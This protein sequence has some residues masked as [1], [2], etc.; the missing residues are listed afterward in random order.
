MTAMAN[1]AVSK[2]STQVRIA[3]SIAVVIVLLLIGGFAWWLTRDATVKDDAA[4]ADIGV[5]NESNS[6][7]VQSDSNKGGGG[8]TESGVPSRIEEPSHMGA[9]VEPSRAEDALSAVDVARLLTE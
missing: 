9:D 2:V 1:L 7:G 3:L 4:G 8:S 5:A 6:D